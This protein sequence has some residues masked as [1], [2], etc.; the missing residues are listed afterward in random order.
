[1]KPKFFIRNVSE[2]NVKFNQFYTFNHNERI[3]NTG[4]QN[5][6]VPD[7]VQ[8]M[9]S[10]YFYARTLNLK[11]LKKTLFCHLIALWTEKFTIL[12]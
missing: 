7:N 11:N 1:M 6:Q 4:E 2:G 3:V 12:K 9:V 5:I 8:D 10:C